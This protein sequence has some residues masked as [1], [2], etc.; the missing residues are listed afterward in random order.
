MLWLQSIRMS[1]ITITRMGEKGDGMSSGRAYPRT[2]PGERVDDSGQ[3]VSSSSDRVPAPCPVFE[4]CGGCKLQHWRDA[5]YH[6]WK[7]SLLSTA[8]A[9]RG[10]EPKF[11]PL[12]DAHGE[13]RRRVGLHVREIEERW[14]AGFMAE[15]SHR[16]VPI[17]QCP[18][19]TPKLQSAPEIAAKF[20]ALFGACDVWITAAD[21]GLDIAVKAERKLADRTVAQFDGLMKA[22]NIARIA[23]NGETR[24]QLAPPVVQM[25]K[26]TVAI[27]VGGFLQATK[28]GEDVLAQLILAKAKKS[29]RVLDLFCGVGPFTFRLSEGRAVH[30][31]DSD[32]PSIAALQLA[33]RNTQGLK[34]ITAEARDLFANPFTPMELNEFDLVL[35]D[36]PRSGAESQCASLGKSKVK[37]VIYVSCDPQSLVRDANVLCK[38]G[39]TIESV[40]PVD[41]FKF[42]AHIEAVAIF[43]RP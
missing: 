17:D 22:N 13:G 16:L 27:P 2:L 14:R 26:A 34:P 4:T 5:P 30:S 38:S 19:L 10:L 42:S 39:F 31:V 7:T 9:A 29:R 6:A 35:L 8:F 41:Q 28:R 21:N 20:G 12:I 43:K 23:V 18:I 37:R 40:T 3:I 33:L 25:G 32:K 1:E 11:E 15:G 24:A 36:P